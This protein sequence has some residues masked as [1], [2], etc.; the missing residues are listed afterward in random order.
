MKKTTVYIDEEDLNIL[1]TSAFISN[2]TVAALIRKS[3]KEF[4][5]K[6][7]GNNKKIEQINRIRE[8]NEKYS[9]DEITTL[10]D[11]AKK[12]VRIENQEK[13]QKEKSPVETEKTAK[14]ELNLRVE[15]N[16]KYVRGKTKT[17]NNIETY[18]KHNYN[19]KKPDPKGWDYIIYVKYKTIKDLKDTVYDIL[20]ELELEADCR[21]GF[22]EANAW[23]E[24]LELSW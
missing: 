1:K 9:F 11:E 14:I 22:I 5:N 6:L 13:N 21:N 24:E 17:R 19:M 15:N 8:Q 16:S 18:L 3:I 10:V 20:N 7:T 4:C 23:C 2:T 12:E